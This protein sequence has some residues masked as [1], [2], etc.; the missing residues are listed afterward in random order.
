MLNAAC[1]AWERN[2]LRCA[3]RTV[4]LSKTAHYYTH[5]HMSAPRPASRIYEPNVERIQ[6]ENS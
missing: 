6:I 5:T 1:H 4:H 3:H 2:V